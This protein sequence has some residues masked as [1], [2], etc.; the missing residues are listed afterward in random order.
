[1]S[2]GYTVDVKNLVDVVDRMPI[3]ANLG[4]QKLQE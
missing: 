2:S 4:V 3:L 1:M